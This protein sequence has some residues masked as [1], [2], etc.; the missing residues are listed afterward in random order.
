M[1]NMES[2]VVGTFTPNS[3]H[4][5]LS[6]SLFGGRGVCGGWR[7]ELVIYVDQTPMNLPVRLLTTV[8]RYNRGTFLPLLGAMT[9]VPCLPHVWEEPGRLQTE[10]QIVRQNSTP[11]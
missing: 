1:N 3:T 4:Q 8:P 10:P 11:D 7:E 2:A 5:G 6:L 9:Q